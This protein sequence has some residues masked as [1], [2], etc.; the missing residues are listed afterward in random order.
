[1]GVVV[2]NGLYVLLVYSNEIVVVHK[3]KILTSFVL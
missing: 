1:M 3:K 2:L